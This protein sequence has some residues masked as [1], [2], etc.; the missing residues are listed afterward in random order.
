MNDMSYY[1][2]GIYF[3]VSLYCFVCAVHNDTQVSLNNKNIL[4]INKQ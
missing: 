3:M 1:L 4:L 2:P